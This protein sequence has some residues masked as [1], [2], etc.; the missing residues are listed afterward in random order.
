VD[1]G[2]FIFNPDKSDGVGHFK[3]KQDRLF[4]QL[5]ARQFCDPF[6]VL[7]VL[8]NPLTLSASGLSHEFDRTEIERFSN[9]YLLWSFLISLQA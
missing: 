1:A 2:L 5:R 9:Y 7:S 4:K 6:G 8:R 3:A